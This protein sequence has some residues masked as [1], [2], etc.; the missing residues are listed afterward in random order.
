MF[1]D[2]LHYTLRLKVAVAENN[3]TAVAD[4]DNQHTLMKFAL[5]I[6]LRLLYS[7]LSVATH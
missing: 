1:I 2:N 4:Q 3:I 7:R 6:F 5:P